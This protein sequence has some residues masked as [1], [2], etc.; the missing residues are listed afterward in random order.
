MACSSNLLLKW[1]KR[2]K[3]K[4]R[5]ERKAKTDEVLLPNAIY[6]IENAKQSKVVFFFMKGSH[7]AITNIRFFLQ[8]RSIYHYFFYIIFDRF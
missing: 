6:K 1:L 8:L 7:F 5:K 2:T 3:E 4:K